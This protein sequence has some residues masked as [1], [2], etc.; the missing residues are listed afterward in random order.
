MSS[1]R[2]S[3]LGPLSARSR[4]PSPQESS[5][6]GE[7]VQLCDLKLRI[8]DARITALERELE[9]LLGFLEALVLALRGFSPKAER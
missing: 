8:V 5:A 1:A 4:P 7:R 3:S 6:D 2:D 9:E